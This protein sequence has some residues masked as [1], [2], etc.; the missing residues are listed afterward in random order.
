MEENKQLRT[1]F[2]RQGKLIQALTKLLIDQ[3]NETTNHLLNMQGDV[4]QMMNS[5]N[6]FVRAET[7]KKRV[8]Q[9]QGSL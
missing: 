4:A 5:L 3:H 7:Q 1:D 9:L 2:D 8:T 6:G